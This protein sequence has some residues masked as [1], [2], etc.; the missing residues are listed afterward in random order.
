M[1][2]IGVGLIVAAL[3]VGEKQLTK[4]S[5]NEIKL[6]PTAAHAFDPTSSGGDGSEH[7]DEVK[8]AI[9]GNPTGT[10]WPTETYDTND[11]GGKPGVGIYVDAGKAV[12]AKAVEVRASKSGWSGEIRD[13]PGQRSAP[14]TLDGWQVVGSGSALGT[15]AKINLRTLEPSRYYLLWITKLPSAQEGFNIEISDVRLLE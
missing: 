6:T 14:S 13:A 5:G 4:S 10:A 1:G 2:L 15:R 9:D 3:I 8:L 7:S 11:I 12:T